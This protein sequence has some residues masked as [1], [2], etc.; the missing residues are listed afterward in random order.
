[1]STPIAD[2]IRAWLVNEPRSYA[3]LAQLTG[4]SER[5]LKY[6]VAGQGMTLATAEKLR[7]YADKSAKKTA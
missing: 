7:Q 3:A 2:S 4:V 5:T 6:I 1:M